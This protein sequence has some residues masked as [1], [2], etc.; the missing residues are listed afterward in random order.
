[1]RQY[2][3]TKINLIKIGIVLFFLLG[4]SS[5]QVPDSLLAFPFNE[6]FEAVN[7]ADYWGISGSWSVTTGDA[8]DGLKSLASNP[9]GNYPADSTMTATIAVN[10]AGANSPSLFFWPT[11]GSASVLP[12]MVKVGRNYGLLPVNSQNGATNSLICLITRVTVP[13]T[14]NSLLLQAQ[15]M[16]IRAGILT[17][18]PLTIAIILLIILF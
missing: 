5:A 4:V 10:L 11:M 12:S 8:H 3:I 15:Q 2:L 1:M 16:R 7:L 14:S 6:D 17:I 18:S 9:L 13:F